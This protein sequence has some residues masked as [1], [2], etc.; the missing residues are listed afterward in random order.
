MTFGKIP[1]PFQALVALSIKLKLSPRVDGVDGIGGIICSKCL[2][3]CLAPSK[4][5][6]KSFSSGVQRGPH[7]VSQ[8]SVYTE[9]K[10]E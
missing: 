1:K 9:N 5:P 7:G 8:G 10:V 3:Q 6:S 2:E 4:H